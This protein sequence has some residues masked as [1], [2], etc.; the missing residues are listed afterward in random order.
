MSADRDVEPHDLAVVRT[1][2]RPEISRRLSCHGQVSE[3]TQ[4]VFNS[5]ADWQQM[6]LTLCRRYVIVIPRLE[7]GL[8]SGA[9]VKLGNPA[10]VRC[11]PNSPDETGQMPVP[12]EPSQVRRRRR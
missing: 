3:Q 5:L 7:V 10:L 1:Q 4:L 2:E 12:A 9:N 8:C 11:R 6:E